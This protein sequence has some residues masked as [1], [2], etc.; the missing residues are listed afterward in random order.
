MD[1]LFLFF[2]FFLIQK[3]KLSTSRIGVKDNYEEEL[4]GHDDDDD[5]YQPQKAL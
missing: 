5:G 3:S 4:F 1:V 2:I